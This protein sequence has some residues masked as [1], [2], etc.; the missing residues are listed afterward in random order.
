M[1]KFF[2]TNVIAHRGKIYFR[3][4]QGND[5][6]IKRE[7]FSPSIFI[8]SP[9]NSTAEWRSIYGEPLQ[10]KKFSTIKEF[11]DFVSKHKEV[12]N[13]HGFD[14]V[15]DQAYAWISEHHPGVVEFDRDKIRIMIFD[16]ETESADGFPDIWEDPYN[17]VIS[18][19]AY[20]EHLGYVSW[21]LYKDYVDSDDLE[22]D[23]RR[24]DSEEDLLKDFIKFIANEKPDAISGWNTDGFDIP[25]IIN[26]IKKYYN[27]DWVKLLS[28]WK[29]MPEEMTTK[30]GD[31]IY[32]IP[33]IASFDY[34]RLYKKF[35]LSP[36]ESYSLDY[37][38]YVELGEKKIDY[39]EYD[40]LHD[41]SVKNWQKFMQYNKRDVTLVKRLDDKKKFCDLAITYAYL[42]KANWNDVYGTVKYWDVYIY[43]H[44]KSN[45]MVPPPEKRNESASFPGGFVKEPHVGM[46]RWLSIFDLNSLYPNVM[47]EWNISPETIVNTQPYPSNDPDKNDIIDSIVEGNFDN[48]DIINQ[49]LIMAGNGQ[50]FSKERQG[51]VPEIVENMYSMRKEYK[52]KMIEK[53]KEAEKIIEEIARRKKERA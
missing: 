44:L 2:Y 21:G 48:N 36:R 51:F 29:L 37:I 16:I 32:T 42:A 34:M 52:R 12:M 7:D 4:Y 14:R 8:E 41:L 49:D 26:R 39:S 11:T 22:Y 33:G 35:E 43:N 1:D 47:V 5:Q 19:T 25:Y 31:R 10:E 18:I 38:C 23:Y 45:K 17:K 46:Q 50:Y 40:S 3:G 30:Q 27:P 9:N 53:E 28:P 6:I 24:F 15:S 13:L 20:M